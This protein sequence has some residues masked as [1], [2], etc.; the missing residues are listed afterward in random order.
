[1]KNLEQPN[2]YKIY[3]HK[4]IEIVTNFKTF[5]LICHIICDQNIQFPHISNEFFFQ[6]SLINLKSEKEA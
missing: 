5:E 6:N 4:Y 3:F 2:C 1:M